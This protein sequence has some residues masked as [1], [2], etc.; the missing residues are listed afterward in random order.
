MMSLYNEMNQLKELK[1]SKEGILS[2]FLST[3]PNE[4]DKWEINL[5]NG[6]KNIEKE[7]EE[8]GETQKM[9][10]FVKLREKVER[11]LMNNKQRILRSVVLYAEGGDGIFELHFLQL[12]VENEIVYSDVPSMEQLETLDRKFPKTGLIVAQMEI[13]TIYNTRLGEIEDTL[14]FELDLNTDN[15]RKYQGRSARDNASS[16]NQVDQYDSR[17]E[18]QIRSFYRQVST[19]ITK[20]YKEYEWTE[21]VV[22][23]HQRTSK[24]LLDELEVD[25][26][27]IINK[28]L[29]GTSEEE[30]LTAA[31][32]Y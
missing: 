29:G 23:G 10:S 30:V 13:I 28:N 4:R 16:S 21:L 6:L 19:E 22:I 7:L 2:I 1:N 15:W 8:K 11:E 26:S 25:A 27:R 31:F 14:V 18:K 9:Q 32:E 24:L 17:K 5:K 3:K 12:D 20:L